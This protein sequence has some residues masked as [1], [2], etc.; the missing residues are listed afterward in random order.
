MI[1]CVGDV[2]GQFGPL[3][4]LVAAL[5]R[6]LPVVQV[7]DL[8][9]Y[10]PGRRPPADHWIP[11]DRTVYF[12][13]GNHD[14]APPLG[15]LSAPTEVLPG[16]VY[17][18]AG[19]H[20]LGGLRVGVLGGAES[21]DGP[22]RT[23]GVDWWPDQEGTTAEELERLLADARHTRGVD[24]LVTHTP[25]ASV[26]AAMLGPRLPAPDAPTAR[27][28]GAAPPV[29][30]PPAAAPSSVRV[31]QAWHVLGRPP[32]VCGHM[33]RPWRE[34]V[35]E[36]LGYLGVTLRTLWGGEVRRPTGLR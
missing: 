26:V 10:P 35:V 34:G 15:A 22:A 7:G 33:H 3:A 11:L 2:H 4:R 12:V 20:L 27:R 17:L 13:R 30:L 19:V 8:A 28:A 18:P 9:A 21:V 24:L 29:D 23:P 36:V 6:T 5:P 16:L 31:E 32:L 1:A 14:Y 25:P